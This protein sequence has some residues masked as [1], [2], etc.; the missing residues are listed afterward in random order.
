MK[1]IRLSEIHITNF[2][3]YENVFFED[4]R[5]YNILIG[6]NNAGKSNLFKLLV[7][8]K[9]VIQ[10]GR[11][12]KNKLFDGNTEKHASISLYFKLNEE[13]RKKLFTL[14]KNDVSFANVFKEPED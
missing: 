3:G 12:D 1:N 7:E 10:G 5:N 4:L 8:L 11:L 6:Q 2:F 14:L 9:N 13:F